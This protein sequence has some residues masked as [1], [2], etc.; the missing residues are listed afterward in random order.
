MTNVG[1]VISSPAPR[2]APVPWGSVVLPPPRAPV[3]TTGSPSC[4]RPARSRPSARMPCALGTTRR[5]AV[6][7]TSSRYTCSAR[8]APLTVSPR[9]SASWSARPWWSGR[10]VTPPAPS[11]HGCH[12]TSYQ[13][14][15]CTLRE[16]RVA[17]PQ[18][19]LDEVGQVHGDDLGVLEHE[20]V[21]GVAD[22]D[23]LGARDQADDL[24]AVHDRREQIP[25]ADHH[26]HF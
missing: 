2:P 23:V 1:L 19:P 24:L 8:W 3:G 22:D 26:E 5:T 15:S 21:S 16:G 14:Q 4:S 10:S 18:R 17:M 20:Q 13:R 11:A 7:G 25:V 6:W 12:R 9:S